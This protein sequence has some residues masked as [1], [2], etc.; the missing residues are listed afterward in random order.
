MTPTVSVPSK[1]SG[2]PIA[3]TQSPMRTSVDSTS[4][5][6]ARSS[7]TL[8]SN[9]STA[10]SVEGSAP[11]TSTSTSCPDG[12]TMSTV[13]APSTTWLL[14]ITWPSESKT[15]P[16]PEENPSAVSPSASVRSTNARTRTTLGDTRSATAGMLCNPAMTSV[17]GKGSVPPSGCT[18]VS[19]EG[20]APCSTTVGCV[21]MHALATSAMSTSAAA[22]S[23]EA[24][25]RRIKAS[26]CASLR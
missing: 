10:I 8:G 23:V 26:S 2:L 7:T 21:E 13:V 24:V 20:V 9:S 14:V 18:G 16:E 3:I 22:A 6:T 19:G 11:T 1:P 15:T 17:D 5:V 4:G 25:G 12:K